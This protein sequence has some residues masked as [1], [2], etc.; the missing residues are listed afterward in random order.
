MTVTWSKELGRLGIRC[1]AVAP[2]FIGTDSTRAALSE[3]IIEHVRT[4]TPL[5]R[6]GQP[7]EVAQAVTS[8]IEND[9][10]N[11]VIIDVNGGLTI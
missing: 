7:Q 3:A 5:R 10:M 11:G 6:L 4:N 1:N 2:G 9:F 8:L